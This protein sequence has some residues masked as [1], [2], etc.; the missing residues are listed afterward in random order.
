MAVPL[1]SFGR[2]RNNKAAGPTRRRD[3]SAPAVDDSAG[4]DPELSSYL[5]A[6]APESDAESTGSGRRFGEAQVYQ[7][8]LSHAAGQQLKELAAALGT[9]PQALAQE[10]VLE[11]LA[12]ETGNRPEEPARHLPP[13]PP[14]EPHP[15]ADDLWPTDEPA[16]EELFLN[17]HQWP[18]ESM[19]GRPH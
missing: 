14:A 16:T 9:S 11:R 5:A 7:L 19:P 8:R 13:E 18:E 4:E 12:S 6:L 1:P 17:Q 10:W 15:P 2:S 3:R